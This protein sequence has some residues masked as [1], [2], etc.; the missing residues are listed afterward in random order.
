M[1]WPLLDLLNAFHRPVIKHRQDILP[2]CKSLWLHFPRRCAGRER[3]SLSAL[4]TGRKIKPLQWQHLLKTRIKN[5]P[6]SSTV[7][8][9]KHGQGEAYQNNSIYWMNKD[10]SAGNFAV[11]FATPFFWENEC[12]QI[13]FSP[14]SSDLAS[15]KTYRT[16]KL[17]CCLP[18]RRGDIVKYSF[19][20]RGFPEEAT[21]TA[22]S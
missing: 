13:K 1:C 19:S 11:D 4:K 21:I 16:P 17:F 14:P 8:G 15:I 2:V 12:T 3:K 6:K 9:W 18:L 20:L 22:F 10:S 5:N 7:Q